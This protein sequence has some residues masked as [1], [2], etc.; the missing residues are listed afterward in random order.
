MNLT[1]EFRYAVVYA[2]TAN[3]GSM[4]MFCIDFGE[5]LTFNDETFTIEFTDGVIKLVGAS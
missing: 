3:N 1:G 5:T 4:L 2:E